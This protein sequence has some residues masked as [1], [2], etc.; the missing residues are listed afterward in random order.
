MASCVR[1]GQ[2]AGSADDAAGIAVFDVLMGE[3]WPS[4]HTQPCREEMRPRLTRSGF[5][6]RQVEGVATVRSLAGFVKSM[7]QSFA[8]TFAKWRMLPESRAQIA[9]GVGYA[10]RLGNEFMNSRCTAM[11]TW[12]PCSRCRKATPSALLPCNDVVSTAP[13]R[14]DVEMTSSFPWPG[15]FTQSRF[16]A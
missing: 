10:T 1:R 13:L 3:F 8:E 2:R 16:G 12:P 6:M 4:P 15:R 14:A 5:Q 7:T 9:Q 11:P